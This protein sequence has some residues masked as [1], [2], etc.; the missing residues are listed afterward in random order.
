MFAYCMKC[1]YDS[2]GFNSIEELKAQVITDGGQVRFECVQYENKWF[3]FWH[4][5]N[6]KDYLLLVLPKLQQA[7]AV[8]EI[9]QELNKLLPGK[10]S[11]K[12]SPA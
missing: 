6:C 3:H 11:S 1:L 12:N 10:E 7:T 8:E 5:P 9:A 2:G 4:C